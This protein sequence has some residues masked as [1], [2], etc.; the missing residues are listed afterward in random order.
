MASTSMR[1]HTGTRALFATTMWITSLSRAVLTS[2]QI[3]ADLRTM[4]FACAAK[5]SG[6]KGS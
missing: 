2:W 1:R 4:V 5:P 3:T 6:L